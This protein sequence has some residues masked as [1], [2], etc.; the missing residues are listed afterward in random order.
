MRVCVCVCLYQP[1]H[2]YMLVRNV[3][4]IGVSFAEHVRRCTETD[5]SQLCEACMR[6]GKRH[7]ALR[8]YECSKALRGYRQRPWM[9]IDVMWSQIERSHV[10]SLKHEG[11]TAAREYRTALDSQL[12]YVKHICSAGIW[13]YSACFEWSGK[14]TRCGFWGSELMEA[15]LPREGLQIARENAAK[16]SR[17]V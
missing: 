15:E 16:G 3:C 11:L 12:S 9:F 4:V 10:T 5:S 7:L 6:C 8:L 17:Y 14:E 2:M 1:V 13:L